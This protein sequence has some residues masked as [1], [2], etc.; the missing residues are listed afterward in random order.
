MKILKYIKNP[1][2]VIRYLKAKRL[3]GKYGK[4]L[5]DEEFLKKAFKLNIKKVLD[6]DNPQSF[7]EK[8]QWL[9]LYDR[10]NDSLTDTVD[11][12]AVKK[13]IA[14]KIGEQYVIKSYGVWDCFEEIDF[15]KLPNQF[16]LKTTHDCGGVVICKDKK[17]F[18]YEKAKKF[19]EEHLQRRYFYQAR[20][21]PYKNVKPRIL[22]EEFVGREDECLVV[23][24]VFCFG[25]NPRL[26]QVIQGDK[27]KDETID[28]FDENWNLLPLRQNYPNSANHLP[29]PNCLQEML[30]L[31]GKLS[32]HRCFLR[33]DWYVIDGQLKFSEF[34]YYSDAGFAKFEPE[35]WDYKRGEWIKLPKR[36]NE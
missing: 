4:S 8:I 35:V 15:E 32:S 24:K 27:S 31:S 29:K 33:V 3:A 25:G 28:Y 18:N 9:K 5:R 12:Y 14:D 16:V 11:K 6:L 1:F 13:I 22:A 20:E 2:L 34:T 17:T 26:I 21:W 36:G 23:Y 10:G 19:L 30:E 7:N